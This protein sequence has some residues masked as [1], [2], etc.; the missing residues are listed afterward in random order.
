MPDDTLGATIPALLLQ[1]LLEN[2]F[3]HGVEPSTSPVAITVGARREG[4]H[5]VIDVRNSG[6]LAPAAN[7]GIGLRNCRERLAVMHGAEALLTLTADAGEVV[8]RLT[9]PW[10]TTA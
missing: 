2:A 3:K 4:E 9:L 5:L 8:A 7:A 10:R 6:A 1:P